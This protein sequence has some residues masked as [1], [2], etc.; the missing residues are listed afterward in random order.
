MLIIP[1]CTRYYTA[2]LKGQEKKGAME[3]NAELALGKLLQ[4]RNSS[5]A[6]V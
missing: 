3:C 1:F 5:L 2:Y 6:G 4:K